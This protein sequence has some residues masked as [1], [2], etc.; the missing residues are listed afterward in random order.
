[1]IQSLLPDL[2]GFSI[3]EVSIAHGVVTVLA[4][5][6]TTSSRCPA[7]SH[8]SLRVH[9]RYRRVLSDLPCSGRRVRLVLQVRRFF[10]LWP[11]CSRKTFAEAIP[12]ITKRYA[13]RTIRLEEVLVQIGLIAGAEP[14]ARLTA[15]L[16]IACS[17]DTLLRCV[18]RV[19]LE[20]PQPPR[21]VGI[22]DWCATRGRMYSCK[23]SRKEDLT[24]DSALS[25]LPG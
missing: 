6:Q 21:V 24:W 8:L 3:E 9:S 20:P 2:P 25:A 15:P 14:G 23:D 22:D 4:Q 5:S 12:A 16:G 10:C 19:R 1:M 7:C 17:S 11:A 13:R 18:H